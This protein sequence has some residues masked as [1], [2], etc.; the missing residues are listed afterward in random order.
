MLWFEI[1]G[2]HV[3]YG[4]ALFIL[5]CFMFV[6][7]GEKEKESSS[8]IFNLSSCGASFWSSLIKCLLS[9]VCRDC[10]SLM[11]SGGAQRKLGQQLKSTRNASPSTEQKALPLRAV[12]SVF[13]MAAMSCSHLREWKWLQWEV[14]SSFDW[15][16]STS[17][18]SSCFCV[19]V[20]HANYEFRVSH[21]KSFTIFF[22]MSLEVFP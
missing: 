15:Q 4:F 9:F 19:I 12:I 3:W 8:F 1:V 13:N 17:K 21:L 6:L 11:R 22:S 7:G 2:Y 14:P 20:S 16:I 18:I 5:V 10:C